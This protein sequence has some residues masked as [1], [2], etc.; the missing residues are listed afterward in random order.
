MAYYLS[1]FVFRIL[2]AG[3]EEPGQFEKK[4]CLFR[5]KTKQQALRLAIAWGEQQSTVFTNA[6][7]RLIRWEF[8][9]VPEL[10]RMPG[11]MEWVELDSQIEEVPAVEEFTALQKDKQH[12]L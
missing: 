4:L 1:K 11:Q 6:S 12:R 3:E 7:G 9:A 5:A 2:I 8:I 10:R